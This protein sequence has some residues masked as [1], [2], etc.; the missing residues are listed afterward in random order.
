MVPLSRNIGQ[1][2]MQ[3]ISAR[4]ATDGDA[5]RSRILIVEDDLMIALDLEDTLSELGFHVAG[6]ASSHEH[7]IKLAPDSDI[8]FVDVNLSDGA[9]GPEIGRILAERFGISVVFM[10]GNAELVASGVPGTL[11]VVSKPVSSATVVEMLK[12]T[13]AIRANEAAPIP[14]M[15]T[16]FAP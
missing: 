5:T 4:E 6:L 7:A 3:T 12:Y 1:I 11:G 2:I 15:L 16:V 8:A 10:T 13:I 9:S 14:S